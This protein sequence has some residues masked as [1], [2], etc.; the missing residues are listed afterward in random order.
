MPDRSNVLENSGLGL[1]V[2][3]TLAGVIAGLAFG[4]I[5]DGFMSIVLVGVL[6]IATASDLLTTRLIV[7]PPILANA[8]LSTE[9]KA[10]TA[11]TIAFSFSLVPSVFGIAAAI[12]TGQPLLALPFGAAAVLT[13]AMLWGCVRSSLTSLRVN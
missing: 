1:I 9:Q 4:A 5:L 7:L 6:L 8:E 13:H 2:A 12:M 10:D 3:L 11:G